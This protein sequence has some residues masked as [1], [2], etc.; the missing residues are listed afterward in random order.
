[1]EAIATVVEKL[2]EEIA[3]GVK[4]V[5]EAKKEFAAALAAL[6]AKQA[7][8][9]ADDAARSASTRAQLDAIEATKPADVPTMTAPAIKP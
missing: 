6:G 3:A 4:S 8:E 9:A 7:Q 1:M 2:F 5:E